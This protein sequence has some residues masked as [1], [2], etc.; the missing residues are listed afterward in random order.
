ML[1]D[2]VDLAITKPLGEGT[3]RALRLW[4]DELRIERDPP[5]KEPGTGEQGS[6]IRVYFVLPKGAYATT[7]IGTAVALEETAA[8]PDA[9]TPLEDSAEA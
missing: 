9:S 1:G 7:V 3:R 5:S 2:G 6:S 8:G 4:I